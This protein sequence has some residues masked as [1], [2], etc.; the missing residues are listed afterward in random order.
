MTSAGAV[1]TLG[2]KASIC[3]NTSVSLRASAGRSREYS[4]LSSS[5]ASRT[6]TMDVYSH[7]TPTMQRSAVDRFAAAVN[8]TV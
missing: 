6:T 8:G 2:G 5:W 3:D 1:D 7:V 4:Q